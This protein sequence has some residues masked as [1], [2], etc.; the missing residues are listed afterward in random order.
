MQS[1]INKIKEDIT[2]RI[3]EVFW[4][5]I[6][7]VVI[8]AI[9]LALLQIFPPEIKVGVRQIRSWGVSVDG[10]MGISQSSG[11]WKVGN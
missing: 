1:V 4:I 7:A 10:E 2:D 8:T 6:K 11:Y 5:A 9:I 3:V